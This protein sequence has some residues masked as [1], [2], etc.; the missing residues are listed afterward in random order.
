M[1]AA[2]CVI[3]VLGSIKAGLG[4]E[5]TSSIVWERPSYRPSV[6]IAE[7]RTTLGSAK[8]VLKE[9]G[10]L[11]VNI[12]GSGMSKYCYDG[13]HPL[14]DGTDRRPSVKGSNTQTSKKIM[15]TDPRLRVNKD[16]DIC[17]V[18]EN[19]KEVRQQY[20]S[21]N[22]QQKQECD[23][24]RVEKA[25]WRIVIWIQKDS[26]SHTSVYNP[27]AV[28]QE[29]TQCLDQWFK[30][31]NYP[32]F[33]RECGSAKLL[34]GVYMGHVSF[35]GENS[36]LSA[37]KNAYVRLH[38]RKGWNLELGRTHSVWS[39]G[40]IRR[41]ILS[42]HGNVYI[43]RFAKSSPYLGCLGYDGIGDSNSMIRRADYKTIMSVLNTNI[44]GQRNKS[45]NQVVS[46][47]TITIARIDKVKAKS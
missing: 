19:E 10:F 4:T 33:S 27:D 16:D 34:Q 36:C 32:K 12:H 42:W 6:S 38:A 45:L 28:K 47:K 41:T 29:F 14:L 30:A 5:K 3:I 17:I 43:F 31:G 24:A 37:S 7:I 18:I 23:K 11:S 46:G 20:K 35:F 13:E 39:D 2:Q 44:S 1:L 26:E 9:A 40:D 21:L 22:L 8:R 25:Q 15:K